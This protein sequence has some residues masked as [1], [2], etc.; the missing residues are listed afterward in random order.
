M[1]RNFRFNIYL[2]FIILILNFPL[3]TARAFQNQTQ[4][5]TI[6]QKYKK[7]L[8]KNPRDVEVVMKLANR[9]LEIDSLNQ[10][11]N[12]FARAMVLNRR[13]KTAYNGLGLVYLKKGIEQFY[14]ITEA[15]KKLFKK[16]PFAK[17][18]EFFNK[19]L[20]I[21]ENYIEAKYNLGRAYY[22]RGSQDENDKAINIFKEIILSNTSYK[23]AF[24]YLGR[25]YAAKANYLYI[26]LGEV[27]KANEVYNE[28]IKIYKG[29]IAKEP[30]NPFPLLYLCDIYITTERYR[31]AVPCYISGLLK[32]KDKEEL[33]YRF[34]NVKMLFSK[35]E[36]KDYENTPLEEK[37]KF[38]VNFWKKKDTNPVT[39]E[40][41]RLLEHFKRLHHVRKAYA[42]K[43][44][45]QG[46]DDR[47][48]IYLKYG[49]P[50]EFYK[51]F[52][53]SNP[54]I[55]VGQMPNE[56]WVY[57]TIHPD[58]FFDFVNINGR[59][60]KLVPNLRSAAPT[61]SRFNPGVLYE[62]YHQRAYLGS[63][64][65]KMD[66]KNFEEIKD[67]IE[68]YAGERDKLWSELPPETY[69]P[70]F[71]EKELPF[72]MDNAQ[73][74][75]KNGKTK[76]E[77]YYSVPLSEL[78]LKKEK[79]NTF[80]TALNNQI[81]FVDSSGNRIAYKD[82]QNKIISKVEKQPPDKYIINDVSFN[83]KSG[84]YILGLQIG[85]IYKEKLSIVK[86]P[87]RVKDFNSKELM[88]SDIMLASDIKTTPDNR[89]NITAYPYS[90]INKNVPIFI[91]FEIYNLTYDKNNNT[92]FSVEYKAM[93]IE[94]EKKNIIT[95]PFRKLKN[96]LT[97]RKKQFISL[98]FKRTGNKRDTEEFI[99]FD[100]KELS[101][102]DTK[103]IVKVIDLNSGV[104]KEV[105][106]KI[107]LVE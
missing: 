46:Y 30:D 28:A 91:Y 73:F 22:E 57:P 74:R 94:P 10:A 39:I 88:I 66:N 58:L 65:A 101:K 75:G 7:L 35:K 5:D 92:N 32:L 62:L 34:N 93:S 31:E 63:V 42:T 24:L 76:V 16:D 44:N 20:Q 1:Y 12:F 77:I 90:V 59:E 78:K 98:N 21:D 40:N 47:G 53:D 60:F 103:L 36:L 55:G 80:A 82:K 2:L 25:A 97:G 100:L 86:L 71:N 64:Y 99:K 56:S 43:A 29:I 17:A 13:L 79:E 50:E 87:Y 83:L 102:G 41:E 4:Q 96:L 9:Y 49:P 95:A 19:A 54:Q 45:K 68:Y 6:I 85:D 84:D 105:S 106:K 81:V 3:R 15:V 37:G 69:F 33:E 67:H 11:E 26:T 51:S 14:G 61:G 48:I 27:E 8:F 104:S 107:K 38:I 72:V 89:L 18:I 52:D 70:R 23:N